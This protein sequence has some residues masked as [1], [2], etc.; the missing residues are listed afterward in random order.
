VRRAAALALLLVPGPAAAA[1][2]M[3]VP[4]TGRIFADTYIPTRNPSSNEFRLVSTT[5]WLEGA[6]RMGERSSARFVLEG[7]M[8]DQKL[9]Q[10]GVTTAA[11]ELRMRLREGYVGYAHEGVE[12]RVGQQIIPWGKSDAVN[13]TDYL[14]AKDYTQFNPDDEVRRTGALS[15]LWT[16]TP[17]KGESPFSLTG[18]WTRV[19]PQSRLLIPPV[20]VPAGVTVQPVPVEPPA[21][22]PN[23]ELALKGA[24][25]GSGWDASLSVFRGWNH[26][27]EFASSGTTVFQ[28]FHWARALGG[29][30]AVTSGSWIF[31]AES[32]YIWTENNDGTDPLI[33]PTHWDS[34]LGVERPIGDD[35]RAQLQFLYRYYPRFTDP[36]LS[37]NPL[38]RVNALLLG[39]QDQSRPGYTLRVSYA[40]EDEGVETELFTMGN[41]VGGD[42]LIRPKFTYAW[43]EA[44][45]TTIG[46]DYYGG[47]TDRP[48]GALREFNSLFLEAKYSF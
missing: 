25:T 46:T 24:Y 4:V 20:A 26:L 30:A 18:V 44:L 37:P 32:A 9:P 27:P 22:L 10:L 12:F 38:A 21:T 31:R 6:P 15:L 43:T 8:F 39:Y 14:S 40:L 28:T 11:H 1:E 19:F 42:Y 23:S 41:F 47:P 5:L 3:G 17:R 35:F 2:A 13:P 48:L 33:Q 16:W 34:V 45:K 36:A 7:Q 29:D